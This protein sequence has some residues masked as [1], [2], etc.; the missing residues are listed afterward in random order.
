MED[1]S[2][3]F[4][5]AKNLAR[6]GAGRRG[7]HRRS[8]VPRNVALADALDRAEQNAGRAR[9][10]A[11]VLGAAGDFAG[12]RGPIDAFF[13]GVLV[14]DP[15]IRPSATTACGCSTASSRCSARFA[16]FSLLAG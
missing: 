16:D 13:E 15:T 2:V 12:L 9:G 5:R 14:M 8:W 11:G 7:R 4:T 10:G 1:L 3:A 6:A